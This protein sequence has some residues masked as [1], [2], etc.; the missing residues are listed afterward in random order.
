MGD[1]TV[2]RE[3]LLEEVR[4]SAVEFSP[5]VL[6]RPL[7][8]DTLFPTVCYVAGPNELAYLAQL[9]GI[10]TAF[11]VPMPLI[12]PRSSATL[13][14]SNAMRFLTRHSV[15]LESLQ[16][17]D[18]AVLNAVLASQLPPSVEGSLQ[19]AERVIRERM[20]AVARSVPA[21][22]ATLEAAAR[23]TLGRMHDDLKKLHGKIIQAA[24]RKDETLRRQFRHAQ[25]QAFPSGQPQER[26][27]GF[28]YFL[29]KY[30]PTLVDRLS[31]ELP[32]TPGTHWAITI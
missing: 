9:R 24:K 20:D 16:P 21:I 5:N 12:Q 4:Q 23:S 1:R 17:R 22:D 27:V 7:V 28:V 32:L 31:E 11:G 3:A 30:G 26:E 2:T 13:L 10:Y 14:D 6:L 19:D 25:A 15:P 8:Q 18:E 29:N